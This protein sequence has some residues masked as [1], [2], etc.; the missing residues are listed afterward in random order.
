[1]GIRTIIA[2][3]GLS[4]AIATSVHAGLTNSYTS[5]SSHTWDTA[6]AWSAGVS[7]TTNDASD[8]ITN[9]T[10]KTVS[11][12][13][14]VVSGSPQELT[15]TNLTVWGTAT[16]TNTLNLTN[17]NSA[18]SPVPLK[19]LNNFII[20]DRGQLKINNST[21]QVNNLSTSNS[22]ILSFWLGT[23]AV[24]I[25]VV[26]NLLLGGTLNVSSNAGFTFTTYTLFN[27]GGGLTSNG[28]T[29]GTVPTNTV[30]TINTS[31]PGQVNLIVTPASSSSITG[32]V[33]LISIVR[34][35]TTDMA[36]TWTATGSS[37]SLVQFTSGA[38][39]G[40]YTSNGFADISS[41][42]FTP[43]GSGVFTNTYTD[44]GGATNVPSHFYRVHYFQ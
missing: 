21:L 2:V 33:Q 32:S 4:I 18:A 39:D 24:P 31:T 27:Y 3:V 6:G 5:A 8:F 11:I 37:S 38:I 13:S 34:T 14:I 36:I 23:N 40:S 42:Q 10:S 7:P 12:D 26:N 20:G 9:A 28:L 41:S 19:I 44:P 35:N 22:A 29:V 16:T 30:C 1:M 43:V 25:S 17:M 15:I